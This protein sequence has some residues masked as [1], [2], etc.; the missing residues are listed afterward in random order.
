M[1]NNAKRFTVLIVSFL[2]LV[3]FTGFGPSA[4]A[5]SADNISGYAWSS[6]DAGGMG[7]LSFNCVS[8]GDCGIS[9]YG[10]NLSGDIK[11]SNNNTKNVSF[12]SKVKNFF[13]FVS[14]T[15]KVLALNDDQDFS[16]YAWSSNYGWIKF[17]GL[18]GFPSGPGTTS[19]NAKMNGNNLSGWARACAVF[20]SGCSGDYYHGNGTVNNNLTGNQSNIYL[21]GWDGWISLRGTGYG[22]TLNPVSNTFSGYAWGGSDVTG[23]INFS[24]VVKSSGDFT[25]SLAF[26][27]DSTTVYP[28]SFQ[29]KLNWVSTV[30]MTNCIASNNGNPVTSSWNGAV[31]N[32]NSSK[33]VSV[34]SDPSTTRYDLQ[35]MNGTTPVYAEPVYLTRNTSEE[36][37]LT[38]TTDVV[39]NRVTLAWSVTN[40]VY[41]S[42]VASNNAN[43][44][45]PSWNG[46]KSTQPAGNQDGSGSQANVVVPN[47]A[48]AFTTYT[49]TCTGL[50]SGQPIFGS[51]DLNQNTKRNTNR[52]PPFYVER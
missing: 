34:P 33:T 19:D 32:P 21:G 48:P 14:Q 43:P 49:L 4:Y 36:V 5:G 7:W 41:G 42:C 12:L 27:P 8:G 10:V 40:V 15:P 39:N 26:Y 6:Y 13:N 52:K 30:P 2:A 20:H 35:C 17:G 25:G 45:V 50:Y 47:T 46:S 51:V 29:T 24:N 44:V 3:F 23:W 11:Q 31:A 38:N 37:Y 9:D 28:P 1:I 22:V 18:S 16:G